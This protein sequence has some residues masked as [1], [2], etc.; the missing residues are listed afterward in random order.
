MTLYLSM[1]CNILLHIFVPALQDE[2]KT[3]LFI[4][5]LESFGV[6]RTNATHL[7]WAI[8][9]LFD[10]VDEASSDTLAGVGSNENDV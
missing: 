2:S 1:F 7:A 8:K 3:Q 9:I 10:S 4:T 6:P 5:R